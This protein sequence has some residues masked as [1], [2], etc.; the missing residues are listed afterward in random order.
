MAD[1]WTLVWSP[2]KKLSEENLSLVPSDS[3]V[4]RLSYLAN[5][6]KIYVFYIGKAENLQQRLLDHLYRRD[7]NICIG[8]MLSNATCYFRYAI[9]NRG[10]VRDGAE[11]ALYIHYK[12]QCN[13]QEPSGSDIEINFD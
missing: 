10:S 2:L 8:R 9:V 7:D 4:Y 12:P 11:L 6:E 3:G 1:K 5:D 13:S